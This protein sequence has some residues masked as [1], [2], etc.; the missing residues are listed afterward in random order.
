MSDIKEIEKRLE[1]EVLEFK[2]KLDKNPK[3]PIRPHLRI[4]AREAHRLGVQYENKRILKILEE[5]I[6]HCITPDYQ[7]FINAIEID[8]T[9]QKIK[10]EAV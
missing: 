1:L 2:R 10:K 4:L 3:L 5:M 8:K 9:I 7:G 6:K